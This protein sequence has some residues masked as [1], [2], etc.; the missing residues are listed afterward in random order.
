VSC[1]HHHGAGE[2]AL[3]VLRGRIT[4][5]FGEELRERLELEAGDFAFVPA[6]AIHAEGNV[7]TEVAEVILARSAPEMLTVELPELGVPG[8]G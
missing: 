8:G 1:A 4:L 6:W 7:G 5:F 3:Y 2:T